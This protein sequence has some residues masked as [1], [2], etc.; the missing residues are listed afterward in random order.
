MPEL[1]QEE[2]HAGISRAAIARIR[3]NG[4]SQ[5]SL[6]E[7]LAVRKETGVL[8][9]DREYVLDTYNRSLDVVNLD[10][11][12]FKIRDLRRNDKDLNQVELCLDR[13]ELERL[14]EVIAKMLRDSPEP[15][16]MKGK[17]E[18]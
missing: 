3:R 5:M 10:G 11:F 17:N 4:Q 8:G 14:V 13:P 16:S 2:C 7:H 6:G 15:K 1:T 18:R 12:R 9:P